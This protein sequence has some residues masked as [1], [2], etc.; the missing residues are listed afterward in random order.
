M[1]IILSLFFTLLFLVTGLFNIYRIIFIALSCIVFVLLI[2]VGVLAWR[3]KRALMNK[4][5]KTPE[6][7]TVYE[8]KQHD[9]PR[10]QHVS[11]GDGYM[12]PLKVMPPVTSHYQSIHRNGISAKYGNVAS[13]IE[14][15]N[16]QEDELYLT[17][18]P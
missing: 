4:R 7:G 6:G 18:I 15:D 9:T 5:E 8:G 1:I 10:D 17:I 2:A 13:N 14:T 12:E 11:Q 16:D 3:L